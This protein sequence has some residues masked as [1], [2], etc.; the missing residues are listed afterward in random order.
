MIRAAVLTC[1]VVAAQ[2]RAETALELQLQPLKATVK[3]GE[4]A[5]VRVMVRNPPVAKRVWYLQPG[6]WP[7]PH[8]IPLEGNLALRVEVRDS[9]GRL[10][11]ATTAVLIL[12]RVRTE[13]SM[14]QP[15]LPGQFFGEDIALDSDQWGFDMVPGTY[16]VSATVASEAQSWFDGW[17]R[18]HHKNE[19]GFERDDLFV[20]PIGSPPI[21]IQVIE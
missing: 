17:L 6:F 21:T 10:L 7:L 2:P 14:F 5:V 12:S 20:G 15:L 3:R 19:A 4:S 9:S 8:T 11:P 13:P 18:K 16:T 1:M